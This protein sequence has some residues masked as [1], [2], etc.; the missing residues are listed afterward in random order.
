MYE[1]HTSYQQENELKN[2]LKNGK[3]NSDSHRDGSREDDGYYETELPVQ[4]T[5]R[6]LLAKFQ[7]MQ[8]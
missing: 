8:A 2:E 3:Y 7:A 1:D 4:G 5:T 6:G